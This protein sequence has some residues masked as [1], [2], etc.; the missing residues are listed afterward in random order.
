MAIQSQNTTLSVS[1][2]GGTTW[3]KVGDIQTLGDIDFGTK[4][5]ITIDSLDNETVQKVLG[6][7]TLGS[8]DLSYVFDPTEPNGNGVIKAAHDATTTTPITCRIELPNSL[9]T[10]GTQFDFTAIVPSYKISGLE[11]DGFAK[12]VTTL[13]ITSKPTVTAAA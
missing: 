8:M 2:D 4:G 1:S 9:G 7:L 5:V 10:N 13:E 11:K 6:K 12:S 3:L